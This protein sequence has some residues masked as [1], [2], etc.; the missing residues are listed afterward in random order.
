MTDLKLVSQWQRPVCRGFWTG[1]FGVLPVGFMLAAGEF[2]PPKIEVAEGL[3]LELVAA[4]PLVGYPLMAC[5]DDRGRLYVAESDGQNLTKKEAYLEQRPRFVRRLEDVD[6]DGVF[7]RQTIFAD[8]MTMPEGGFWYRDALYIISAPYLW[9]L[10]DLDDDGIADR[11]EKILGYMEFDGRANQHGPYMGPNGR[12]YFSGGHFGFDFRGSDGSRTGAS[13][14]AGVFSCWPDGSDVRIEG[15]GP[16]NPVDVVFTPDGDMLSTNAIYDSVGGRHD[17]I[18]H[19]IPGGLTQR[20]YGDPVLPDTGFRLPAMTRWGQVAPGG[21]ARIRGGYLGRERTGTYVAC[22]FNGHKVV[23]V[24]LEAQGA[25]YIS[26]EEDLVWSNNVDFHPADVLEDAD[27]SLLILDTGGW[28]SWGCPYSKIAKPE[29]RGAIYRLTRPGGARLK[30]PR[31]LRLDLAATPRELIARLNDPR[32]AVRDRV[33][34]T[35]I[36]RGASV[37]P[38]LQ[39]AM[40]GSLKAAIERR[41]IWVLSRIGTASAIE[42]IRSRVMSLSPEVRLAAIR[43][44]GI[45]GDQSS[46]PQL[47]P[48]L[49]SED[50]P[51]RRRVASA[52]GRLKAVEAVRPL[53]QAFE[54]ETDHYVRHALV[55]SLMELKDFDTM[56]SVLGDEASSKVKMVALRVLDRVGGDRLNAK[57]TVAFLTSSNVALR[58]EAQRIIAGRATWQPELVAMFQQWRDQGDGIDSELVGSLV[59]S[60]L[61]TDSSRAELVTALGSDRLG[62]QKKVTLLKALGRLPSLPEE[63]RPA[64][65]AL[66]E[67]DQPEVLF[68]LLSL[69]PRFSEGEFAKPLMHLAMQRDLSSALRVRAA[70]LALQER[71]GLPQ[72]VLAVLTRALSRKDG[73]PLDRREAARALGRLTLGPRN[74]SNAYQLIHFIP[75]VSPMEMVEILHPFEALVERKTPL[76]QAQVR[77]MGQRLLHQLKIIADRPGLDVAQWHRVFAFCDQSIREEV[78]ALL[79]ARPRGSEEG[80]SRFEALLSGAERGNASRGR[81]VFLSGKGACVTCHRIEGQGGGLGPDLSHIGSIRQKKDLLEAILFPSSTLVNGYESYHVSTH[82]GERM[83]GVVFEE[84]DTAI[85]LKDATQQETRFLREAIQELRPSEISTMPE[86]LAQTMTEQEL[87]DLVD[88][89]AHCREE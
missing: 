18:V 21:F 69:V 6:G 2:T 76:P 46:V 23:N 35:L 52:L 65:T 26:T 42:I 60:L 39:E 68:P 72:S 5:F 50:A 16:I 37:V 43:S 86:G 38:A 40:R 11:R 1:V 22:H 14:S 47:L 49:E 36:K 33:S 41:L 64:V 58:Q 45:L 51:T 44:L 12:L 28:L 61:D 57:Q 9:R 85:V 17:A 48:L 78:T 25:S 31:G 54:V 56:V 89:L 74:S 70:S 27:G 82:S 77:I 13:R 83:T 20:I 88:F 81:A 10:E 71:G 7:D 34:E 4:P 55:Y 30:D 87:L 24:R 3:E 29:I 53:L 75:L 8:Q 59:P 15:Q 67:S 79:E 84:T 62:L 32:P 63:L 66:F 80:R 73:N 19:W